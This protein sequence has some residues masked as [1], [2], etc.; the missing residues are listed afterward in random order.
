MLHNLKIRNYALIDELDIEF[1]SGFS[2]ITGETG[3]GK[4]IILG[5][6]NLVLGGRAD[7][8][9][10]SSG[11]EKCVVEAAFDNLGADVAKFFSATDFDFF[12]NECI[13]RRE[14]L[15]SGKSRA[16]INDT[17]AT[18]GQLKELGKLLIDIHSQHQNLLVAGSA[19]Q[20]NVLDAVAGDAAAVASYARSYEGYR[21]ASKDLQTLR[22]EVTRRQEEEDYLRFSCQQIE[23]AGLKEN[24][25]NNLEDEQKMLSHVEEITS[26][27][28][29][30]MSELESEEGGIIDSL[31][32]CSSELGRISKY[33]SYADPL[34]ERM[35]SAR[36]ELSDIYDELSAKVGDADYDPSRLQEID[37]RLSTIYDLERKF[38][39]SQYDDLIKKG[40]ELRRQ[41]EQIE[42]GSD[43]LRQKEGECARLRQEVLE[44]AKALTSARVKA[45]DSLGKEMVKRLV[46]LGMP[47]VRFK[48]VLIALDE[49]V[50][51]GMDDVEFMFSANKNSALC[52][53]GDVASGGE[54]ARIM[55]CL[56][57][58]VSKAKG[59]PA[60]IFDEIDTGV[61][62]R[63]AEQM[64][65]TMMQICHGGTQVI[66][67]TH[68]PQIA[69]RG[70][71]H[72][73][74]YKNNSDGGASTKIELL[75]EDDRLKEVAKMLS[76]S[77]VSDAALENAR[78]LIDNK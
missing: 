12:D 73:R 71:Y 31:K 44:K 67:I 37:E 35:E 28:S 10:I 46:P 68:L 4:S 40:E 30:V 3:A 33:C 59:L 11:A 6:L 29:S 62:G 27:V 45:A 60:I 18:A 53:V 13:L 66:C 43:R 56:K 23:D 58:I 64:A 49:P 5:A 61:S 20:I 24:E 69:A 57:A 52:K 65:Q 50:A 70:R 39:I 22:E 26:A 54:I 32:R 74:V 55:L 34:S 47:D 38:H 16:F 15:K 75:S 51:T 25:Q 14:I 72:Y 8:K 36:I 76:G 9:T 63:I 1:N 77:K 78:E 2:V 7:V 17:P 41:L 48:V 19:F 21:K 42:V